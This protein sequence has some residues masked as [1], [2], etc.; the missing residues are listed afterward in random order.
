MGWGYFNIRNT[1][2]KPSEVLKKTKAEEPSKGKDKDD[3]DKKKPGKNAMLSFIAA[4]KK[5]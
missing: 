4:N 1:M 5:C 2:F 3:N